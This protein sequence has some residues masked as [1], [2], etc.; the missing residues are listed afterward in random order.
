MTSRS[1]PDKPRALSSVSTFLLFTLGA[2]GLVLVA[3]RS[4]EARRYPITR[5]DSTGTWIGTRTGLLY[6]TGELW[7]RFGAGVGL[8]ADLVTDVELSDRSVWIGTP[9][10]LARLDK[11]SRRWEIFGPPALPSLRVTGVSLDTSDPDHVWVSTEQGLAHYNVRTND[12]TRYGKAHGL[13]S[14]RVN[15]VYFSGQTVWAATDEGLAALDLKTG[16]FRTYTSKDGLA[17]DRVTEIDAE[18][19]NLWLTCDAGVS[20][21][22]LQR[23]MFLPFR[24][25]EGLPGTLLLSMVNLQSSTYFATDGG[26][27]V[28]DTAADSLTPFL[29]QKGLL[30]ARVRSIVSAGGYAWFATDKGLMRFDPSKKVWQYYRVEDG[31]STEDLALVTVAGSILLVF[32]QKGE[33]DT[34]DYAKDEWVDRSAVRKAPEKSTGGEGGSPPGTA[35]GPASQAAGG[36]GAAPPV[37]AKKVK[38]SVSAEFATDFK[39]DV[40]FAKGSDAARE[41]Y[42]LVNTLRLGAGAQWASGRSVDFSGN[43][44]WGDI[45]PIFDGDYAT[46]KSFQ[47]YDVQ[48]RYLGVDGDLLKEAIASDKLRVEPTFEG[49]WLTERT[50]VEGGRVV[51]TAGAPRRTGRAL[52]LTAS[53]GLRRGTPLRVVLR[54]PDLSSLQVKSFKLFKTRSD[55]STAEVRYV[56]PS[57]VRAIL[58]GRELERNVDYFVDHENGV[59][60]IKNTDLVNMMRTLEVELEYEQIPRKNVGVTRSA[61]GKVALTDFLPRDGDIGQL[62]RSGSARWARDE[63]GLF[64][65]IDGGAEQYIN[66]GWEQTLSQDFTWGSAGVTLRIHDMGEDKNAES[67]LLA[68]KL[69]DAK[70]VPGYTD[71]WI[72]KQSSSLSIKLVSGRYYVEISIDQPTME[73]E[74]LSIAGWLVGKLTSASVPTSADA[75]RDLT[76]AAGGSLAITDDLGVGFT[77]LGTRSVDDFDV[78]QAYGATGISRDILAGHATYARQLGR[79]IGLDARFQAGASSSQED[80]KDRTSGTGIL[81]SALLTS[82]WGLLRAEARKYSENYTGIGVARETE[83]CRT[84]TRVCTTPGTTRLDYEVGTD[85]TIRALSWLPVSLGWQRQTSTLGADYA[86]APSDRDREGTRD[87]ASAQVSLDRASI[88]RLTLGSSFIRREDAFDNQRQVRGSVALDTDLAEGLLKRL[89]FKKLYLRGLYEIGRNWVDEF[90]TSPGDEKDRVEAMHHAVGELRVA[91]TLTE[92]GYATIELH[93][94]AGVLSSEELSDTAKIVDGLTYWRLD[95]G[96]GSSYLHGLAARFDTTLW[97]GDDLPPV[98][99]LST[100]SSSSSSSTSSTRKQ[101]ADSRLTGVVDLFP[102]EWIKPLSPVKLNMAYSYT[103]QVTSQSR[104]TKTTTELTGKEICDNGLDDDGDGLADCADPDC[105]LAAACLLKNSQLNSHRAYSTLFW[106]TP[107]KLQVEVYTDLRWSTSD[108]DNVVR[109]VSQEVRSYVTWRPIY[110]SPITF[111]FDVLH[112]MKRPDTYDSV[113]SSGGKPV[114]PTQITWEPA[115]EW[116]R[117]WSPKW[118]H[119]AK[120]DFTYLQTRDYP[121]IRTIEDQYGKKGD[122]ERLDYDNMSVSASV[123]VRRRFEDPGGVWGLRPY[124]R[125]SFKAQFGRG[126]GSQIDDAFCGPNDDCLSNGSET[127][128]TLTLALGLIWIHSDKLLIDFDLTGSWYD[129]DRAPTGST[130]T[131]KVTLSPHVLATV[132]Y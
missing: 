28:Y 122:L 46:L 51:V 57:S 3:S 82:P 55:G 43:L 128:R 100:S 10:G 56:I 90:R 12:W 67:I 4:A 115:L 132:R 74:I 1:G 31:L 94:L 61:S 44:D 97:F 13:P 86:S 77:Y 24:K 45:S 70:L 107:G 69:P 20:R 2:I 112:D 26:L 110:P 58:D 39:Q 131:D 109:A 18:S 79:G 47:R 30:G 7:K 91:P 34:Y 38:L 5:A 37:E 76:V 95:A 80:N 127:S 120:V 6:G 96:A 27:I 50:E 25:K 130:C 108:K 88:P 33:L 49:A 124:A 116:R 22:S 59:L 101:E 48:L 35:A 53:T 125:A 121:H 9:A 64:D 40:T 62:K 105:A 118:W 17:S 78:K 71:V 99:T 42:W 23:R 60:W 81:G 72:E 19:A 87:V 52:T 32:G 41:G 29:H 123:E 11:G 21:M 117:R 14:E 92:S 54:R 85:A 89:R 114:E 63:Q 83:F 102:G 111:R 113:A 15:D 98:D 73:Q 8:P 104:S 65:E 126:L 66:R 93:D 16:R 84:A 36:G 75:L 106:D 68:R 119:L 103:K 129:C